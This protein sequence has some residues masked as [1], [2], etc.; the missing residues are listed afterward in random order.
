MDAEVK[1]QTVNAPKGGVLEDVNNLDSDSEVGSVI[2][3]LVGP[4]RRTAEC[5]HDLVYI[6][7]P[8]LQ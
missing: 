1:R 3:S 8:R 2:R 7:Y 6:K 4:L 5:K